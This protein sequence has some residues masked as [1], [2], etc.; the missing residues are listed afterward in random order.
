MTESILSKNTERH[1]AW[2]VSL[3]VGF[4]HGM[5][6]LTNSSEAAADSR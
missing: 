4:G 3:I 6:P 1:S 2:P 5:T